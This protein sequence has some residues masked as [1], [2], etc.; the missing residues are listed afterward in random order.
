MRWIDRIKRAEKRGEFNATDERLAG[1]YKTCAIGER[2]RDLLAA[3]ITPNTAPSFHL[4]Q[5]RD[6]D[7]PRSVNMRTH[8]IHFHWAI[9]DNRLDEAANRY[10]AIQA[11]DG[12]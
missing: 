6:V 9:M 10:A 3:G 11:W 7:V 4:G 2:M 5:G 8:A 1:D 12:S